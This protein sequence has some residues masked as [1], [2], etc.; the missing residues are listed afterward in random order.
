MLAC[1]GLAAIGCG[2]DGISVREPEAAAYRRDELLAAVATYARGP[3]TPETF[4]ELAGLVATLRPGMDEQVAAQAE[5]QLAVLAYDAVASVDGLP[6]DQ[7]TARLATTV[8]PLAL[9]PAIQALA[10]DGW[11]APDDVGT[12]LQVGEL[13]DAY[14]ARMCAGAYVLEC[15]HIVPEWQGAVLAT[16]AVGRLTTRA[17][18][19]VQDC[20][21]CDGDPRWS[22][23]V[24]RWEAL[25]AAAQ[26][27]RRRADV[28]GA[29]EQWPVAGAAATAWQ[30]A[31]RL[32]VEDD[33]DWLLDGVLVPPQDR[34]T[35]LAGARGAATVL[36]VHVH[37]LT[38][39]A[40]LDAVLQAAASAGYAE[41]AVEARPAAYPWPLLAYRLAVPRKGKAPRVVVGD[42]TVQTYLRALDA[43]APTPALATDPAAA[44]AAPPR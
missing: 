14:V 3:R 34:T 6:P 18:A 35:A 41:V 22:E 1:L 40:A 28:Q 4:A 32:T 23:A 12:V 37:P 9:A 19:A 33:G 16:I 2:D 42:A 39:A 30:A 7:R 10:P 43:H 8:W 15:K 27:E 17:R 13:A 25:D 26:V 21:A 44:S 5:L 29:T 31:P 20:D 11:R 24:R 38:R 36:G